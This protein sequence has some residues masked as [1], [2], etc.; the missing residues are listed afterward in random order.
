M[1]LTYVNEAGEDEAGSENR[2]T[3][4]FDDSFHVS[5][6]SSN[7][8]RRE[9]FNSIPI[10]WGGRSPVSRLLREDRLAVHRNGSD[11]FPFIV[12]QRRQCPRLS[13]F[14]RHLE[15]LPVAGRDHGVGR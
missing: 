9:R 3:S 1:A 7:I 15:Q 4:D 10:R 14:D 2:Q 5:A 13:Q 11:D 8:V 6:I 12:I